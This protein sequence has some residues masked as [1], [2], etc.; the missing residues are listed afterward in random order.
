[1]EGESLG[2]IVCPIGGGGLISGIIVARDILAPDLEVIGA[3]PLLGNDAARSLREGRLVTLDKEPPTIADG[4][5]TVSLGKI[6]YDII[7][8][9]IRRIIEVP[10]DAIAEGLR[11][12]YKYANLKANLP[13]RSRWAR[14][15]RSPILSR[16]SAFAA[17]SAAAMWT[18]IL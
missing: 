12:L 11:T 3:E 10:E 2:C 1:P 9:G 7:S 6:N 4:T 5:R 14:C 8:K 13:A 18:W 17:W 16:A 15:S